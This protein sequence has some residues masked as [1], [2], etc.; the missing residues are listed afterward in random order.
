MKVTM[1]CKMKVRGDMKLKRPSA[2]NGKSSRTALRRLLRQ[3]VNRGLNRMERELD[4]LRVG[5]R[6]DVRRDLFSER[7]A[8]FISE[9]VNDPE[10]MRRIATENLNKPVEVMTIAGPVAGTLVRVGTDYMVIQE[11]PSTLLVVPF[12]STTGIRPQ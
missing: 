5:I 10:G 2:K 9:A 4:R 11:S 8:N 6:R 7:F 1:K 12:H 3:E